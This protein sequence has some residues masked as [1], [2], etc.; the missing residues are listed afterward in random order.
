M[1]LEQDLRGAQPCTT[2]AAYSAN[3]MYECFE[4]ESLQF[5]MLHHGFSALVRSCHVCCFMHLVLLHTHT[6]L[7]SLFVL[8]VNQLVFGHCPTQFSWY[9]D[10]GS[11]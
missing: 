6:L 10:C 3:L 1:K 7:A 11:Q 4:M 2:T 5:S 8:A 9:S